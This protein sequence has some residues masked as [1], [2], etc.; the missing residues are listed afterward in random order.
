MGRNIGWLY[1]IG[2]IIR[3]APWPLVHLAAVPVA[4]TALWH[5]DSPRRQ[6]LAAFY[7]G[8][9][10]QALLLQHIYDYVHVPPLLLAIAVLCQRCVV[11]APGLARTS[12]VALLLLGVGTSLQFVTRQRLACWSDC[13]RD[14]SSAEL[15]DRLSMLPRMSWAELHRV[16]V[17]LEARGIQD[18][19]L[20]CLSTRTIPLY[21]ALNLHASTRY[22][23]LENVL[24]VFKKQHERV[25]A[26][27]AA[28]RQR[29]VVCDVLLTRWRHPASALEPE[30]EQ[31]A[32]DDPE[33]A[34][35][36]HAGLIYQSGR[37][38]VYSVPAADMPA[39]IREN[40][41]L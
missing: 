24:F 8:W 22:P 14:G 31:Q 10:G 38:A 15:R 41:E 39:W 34:V 21:Q 12:I 18:G 1:Q 7:I 9:F 27:V 17:F 28:S 40:L 25:L 6:L 37:Y 4:V 26:D 3:L 36:P 16:Q 19:E 32:S 13:F 29:L 20:T 35:F 30:S 23:F 11:S 33:A 2:P 5:C